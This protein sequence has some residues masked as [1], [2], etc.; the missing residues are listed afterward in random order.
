MLEQ[1][2]RRVNDDE[3]LRL[4]TWLL[5]ASGKQGVPQGVVLSPL[6]R[7]LDLNEVDKMLEQAKATTRH[8]WGTAVE[9]CRFADD[10]VVL[11]DAHSRQQWLRRAVER[12]LREELAKRHVEVNEEKRHRVDLKPGDSF[13]FLGF[14]FRRIHSRSGRWLPLRTP[15]PKARTALLRKLK[16]IFRRHRSGPLR[17]FIEE[18]NPILR[19]WVPYVAFGHSSRCFSYVRR[20]VEQQVRRHLATTRKRPGFGWKRWSRPW[21]YDTMGLFD[22][23]RV[24]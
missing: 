14:A 19:G 16:P 2:A 21:L 6:L 23:Y 3:V 20:W 22:A 12:R 17:G 15:R 4:L 9:Y 18:I 1:V 13:G 7:H 10:L 5:H 24:T 8:P 11:V